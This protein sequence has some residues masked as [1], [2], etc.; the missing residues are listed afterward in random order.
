MLEKSFVKVTPRRFRKRSPFFSAPID[1][2]RLRSRFK[3][4]QRREP[5]L[6]RRGDR[7]RRAG[8]RRLRRSSG[9]VGSGRRGSTAGRSAGAEGSPCGPTPRSTCS[10]TGPCALTAFPRKKKPKD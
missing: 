9:P 1:S 2:V 5:V 10:R 4:L 7:R 3:S 8:C 6:D